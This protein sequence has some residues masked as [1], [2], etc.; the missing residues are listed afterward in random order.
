MPRVSCGSLGGS[1]DG[2]HCQQGVTVDGRYGRQPQRSARR[3]LEHPR[4]N[5]EGLSTALLI[6]AA[7]T[8]GLPTPRQYLVY[9][10]CAPAPWMPRVDDA[11][12]LSTM[13]VL[14]STCT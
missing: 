10:D 14:L 3:C 6:E 9:Q 8:D 4:G 5:F 1:Q 2:L 13:G 11:S 12:R 7:A